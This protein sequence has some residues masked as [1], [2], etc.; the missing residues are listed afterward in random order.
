MFQERA[1]RD[2][3]GAKMAILGQKIT[4]TVQLLDLHALW[5][6][7]P[8]SGNTLELHQFAHMPHD[9]SN[10]SILILSSSSPLPWQNSAERLLVKL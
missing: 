3:N 7:R 8:P 10:E 9:F 4:K 1:K 6:F 2:P 5:G